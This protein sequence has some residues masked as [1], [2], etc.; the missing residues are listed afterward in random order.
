MEERTEVVKWD[1]LDPEYVEYFKIYERFQRL[2]KVKKLKINLLHSFIQKGCGF[3]IIM[4]SLFCCRII[5]EY[6]F[7]VFMF[8]VGISLIVTKKDYLK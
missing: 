6:S 8:P 2:D 1:V 4:L 7:I 5:E 3:L